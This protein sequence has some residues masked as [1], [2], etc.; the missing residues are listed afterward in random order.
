MSITFLWSIFTFAATLLV[1]IGV[2]KNKIESL[3]D[4]VS[5]LEI[6]DKSTEIRLTEIQ[7]QLSDIQAKLTLLLKDKTLS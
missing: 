4:R 3:S 7:C 2:Y 1:C 5:E 6:K